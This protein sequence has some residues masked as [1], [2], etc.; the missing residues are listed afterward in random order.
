MQRSPALVGTVLAAAAWLGPVGTSAAPPREYLQIKD[1][2]EAFY[3]EGSYA[4]AR[5]LYEKAVRLELDEAE[6]RWVGF[7]IADTTWRDRAGSRTPDNTVF[8]QARLKLEGLIRAIER[9]DDRDRVWAEAQESL[10]DFWWS[11]RDAQNWG[12]GWSHYQQAL[13]WWAGH[14]DLQL[15]RRRYLEMVWRIAEP[16]WRRHDRWY[17]YHNIPLEVLENAGKIARRKIDRARAH[18]LIAMGL[19]QHGGS[20]P[21]RLR[22]EGEFEAALELGRNN[23]WYDDALY[24]YAEWLASQGRA[25]AVANGG[26]RQEPDFVKAL[27]L[28]RRLLSEFKKGETPYY[29]DARN[30]ITQ[31]T[32]PQLNATV[33][34]IFLPDSIVRFDLSW[35][36]LKAID[37]ALYRVDLTRDLDPTAGERSLHEW[38]WQIDPAAAEKVRTWRFDTKD[39]GKHTWGRESTPL[40]E[41]LPVGAFL[42]VATGGGQTARELILV[43]DVS[44]V[45]KSWPGRVL[46]YVCDALDGSPIP[47]A[48]VHLWDWRYQSKRWT[49][50]DALARTDHEGLCGF[51]LDPRSRS[52]ESHYGYIVTVS[53]DGRQAF[54][55]GPRLAS[56]GRSESWKIYAT[57]DRPAYRPRETVQW[58]VTARTNDGTGYA[59]PAQQTIRY[60]INGPRGKVEDGDL[61][62]NAFGSAWGELSLSESAALG[63]Y[64][65]S[66]WTKGRRRGIGSATLF[67]LEEYKLP[68][69]EVSVQTPADAQ[70]RKKAFRLGETVEVTIDANYYFGGPVASANVEVLVYQKP[71]YHS[72]MPPRDYPWYYGQRQ[73]HSY[74]GGP[75]QIIKRD[76]LKTDSSGR[77]TLTFETPVAGSQ[78]FEYRVEARVTDASRREITGA[79]TVRVTRQRY[80][81]HPRARLNL[82]RPGDNVEVEF[83]TIDANHDPVSVEGT[84]TVTRERW[85]EVWLDPAGKEVTGWALREAQRRYRVFPPPPQDDRAPWQLKFRGYTSQ[86]ILRRTIRTDAEGEATL[87]F[88]AQNEGYYRVSWQSEDSAPGTPPITAQTTI[89][90]ADHATTELGYRQGGVEIVVDKDTF[91]AGQ[92]A[93][94]MLSVPTNDRYVLFSVE[95]NDM[96]EYRLVH[97]T[98]TVKLIE[99]PIE[100]RHIPNVHL[101][102][103]MVSDGQLFADREEVIVPPVENFLEVEVRADRE[104]YEPRDEGT[105]TVITRDVDGEPVAAEVSLGLVDES[106][107]Y[108]QSP[109]A[110]DPRELFFGERQGLIVQT[111]STFNH[112]R[113]LKLVKTEENQLIDARWMANAEE[114][115]LQ[116]GRYRELGRQ[117]K[118]ARARHNAGYGLDDADAFAAADMA[119]ESSGEMMAKSAAVPGAAVQAPMEPQ[120]RQGGRVPEPAVVVRSDF[121]STIFWRPD[122]T[123][124]TDGKAT[125]SV[126]YADS[127]TRWK[128]TACAATT[129]N[130]FGIGGATTRTRQPLIARL[131]A[132]RFFV[133]GDT[134]TLS[135]VFN[136]NTEAPMT[137]RPALEAEGLNITAIIEDGR[138]TRAQVAAIEVPARSEARIDWLAVVDHP[139]EAKI[140]LSA[141]SDTC[142]DAMERTYRVHEHG[143]EKF[144]ASSGKV[145][146]RAVTVK[147]DIPAQRKADSTTLN[148][149]VT[150]SMAV[151]MLDALPYLIDYPYGCTEQTMSRFL[152]AVV[153]A[154]TLRDLGLSPEDAL[155]KVFGG[156]EQKFVDKTHPKGQAKR[157]NLRKLDRIVQQGLDRLYDF[158]HGDGGW[159]WWKDGQS[160]HFMTAYILWG[161]CLARAADLDVRGDV[162]QRAAR[163]LDLEIVEEE[164][165]LDMQ[166]WMLHALAAYHVAAKQRQIGEHPS[167]ALANLWKGRRNLNAYTR[168]LVALAAHGFGDDEKARVLVRNL[169]NGVKR[170]DAPDESILLGRGRRSQPAVI[171]TAHWGADGV[172]R[173]W[174]SGGV[175][176]TAFALRALMAIEPD[177]ELVEPV[178]N[179]LIKNRRG[180]QWSNTRDTAITV[181]A[182]NDYLRASGELEPELA[183]ELIVNGHTIA[184]RKIT[185]AEALRAPSRFEIDPEYIRDGVNTVEIVRTNGEGPIYFAADA[186]F[187]S[188]EEPIPPA[189][190]EIFVRRDYYKLSPHETLLKGYV[191][192]RA[193]LR[194]GEYVTSGERVQVVV[195]VEAKNDYEYLVFEDLKPAGLEAVQIRSGESMF[196]REL[197]SGAVE[198][199]FAGP[200][201]S[202]PPHPQ[203]G[204]RG[205]ERPSDRD[206]TG[207][208]RWVHQEL[209]DR[210]VALF[211]DKL[212]EGVW[213][214]TYDLRAEVPGQFHA[215]PVL[216]HAMYVPEIRCNSGEVRITV[217]DRSS[218]GVV[219]VGD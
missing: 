186:A 136:N 35:R 144:V 168:A 86:E 3:A 123:T 147:L 5:K 2:A 56:R 176:A 34:N 170:D 12:R 99:V 181:L 175:E 23:P 115:G 135:G 201:A 215:L 70:G 1:R 143:V 184:K 177:H 36:N 173:R 93:A 29:D 206:F 213:E 32:A 53:V 101:Q 10:G 116:D 69:F 124:D 14:R 140:R 180:G 45:L 105:L 137:V 82:Y 107:Y 158:Q 57:T 191:Y 106:V 174:S 98:G 151:T 190:N 145:R 195:T 68:E 210:K 198:R 108:I 171:G 39:K 55:T 211:V 65:V 73:H 62:L 78:D 48:R 192:N 172:F 71:F 92:T 218:D 6:A 54:A 150:P 27:E 179:W 110:G 121:R 208:R 90:V 21:Q 117:E 109:Y 163:Y 20:W 130:R 13:D 15:A 38:V 129:G 111:G 40:D 120:A 216:G 128:A 212:P 132:P 122:V 58:K 30:R 37:L 204:V 119:M 84:V 60:E 74:W 11:R 4:R 67:R 88:P 166:A 114:E 196:A 89:W 169:E 46:A 18:Y 26:W 161:L 127:L 22:I 7:R 148:V 200:A 139:G 72:W 77:A 50:T 146:G 85:A 31:I 25:V 167:A 103:L 28:F 24:H 64:Q 142:A 41:P 141:R 75:G 178:T 61:V 203:L 104:A 52:R 194:D 219:A 160:D 97:V 80:Y 199:K 155:G 19:R 8:E 217:N 154:R 185:P 153:T 159:G 42:L 125:V 156:I 47:G 197:K 63:E 118:A 209:R 33:S 44:V 113:Y 100:Q 202:P 51:E 59:T 214:V 83:K 182:L 66:F 126:K 131:Q 81:V 189:G 17:G 112:K 162:M 193:P 165:H 94:V 79:D 87:A 207:R 91:R 49:G 205:P 157:E 133:V 43:T 164:R 76:M 102:A 152:P 9:P 149:A 138:P 187:F 96:H 188:L 183:Y 134:V 95:G 16:E